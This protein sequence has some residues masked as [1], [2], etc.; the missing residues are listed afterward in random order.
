MPVL[1]VGGRGEGERKGSERGRER[2]KEP[3]AMFRRV[4]ETPVS[5]VEE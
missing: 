4:L 1:S 3:V 5:G 2:G